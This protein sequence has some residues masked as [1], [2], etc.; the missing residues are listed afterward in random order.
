MKKLNIALFAGGN[1]SEREV[2][3]GSA[4]QVGRSLDRSKYEV[5]TIDL[6]GTSWAYTGPDGAR[7]EVDKNDFSLPLPAGRVRLDYALIMIHGT[8]GEDGRLQGYLEMM[9]IP[10]SSCGLASTVLTFDKLLCKRI[11]ASAGLNTAPEVMLYRGEPV[12]A[13]AVAA[14]LGLPL[15]VKPNASGS[16]CGVTRC[17]RAEEIPAAV[18]AALAESPAVMAEKFI[19]GREIGC[20]ILITSDREYILPVTEIRPKKEFFDYEAKYT[21]GMSEEITPADIPAPV[22]AELNRMTVAVYRACGCRGVVRIDFIVTSEGVPYFIEV[23]SVPGMSRGSIVPQ[24]AACAGM[25]L[26]QL[27]DL[28]IKDTWFARPEAGYSAGNKND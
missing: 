10:F 16:S 28:V 12:D 20:G 24:Q 4:E 14:T 27:F 17:N 15:F 18:E 1:S 25:D 21:P 5:Y 6:C 26:G 9:G 22:L 8:P 3:L 11:A 19:G 7:T 23:N 13:A 2:S